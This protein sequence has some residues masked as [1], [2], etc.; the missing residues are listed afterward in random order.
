M[1]DQLYV[2]LRSYAAAAKGSRGGRHVLSLTIRLGLIREIFVLNLLLDGRLVSLLSGLTIGLFFGIVV[3]SLPLTVL[4]LRILALLVFALTLLVAVLVLAILLV[5]VFLAILLV[6][7]FLVLL[8]LICALRVVAPVLQKSTLVRS[9]G[10][11]CKFIDSRIFAVRVLVLI[12]CVPILLQQRH[13]LALI[14]LAVI[15]LV[16]LTLFLVRIFA[17]SAYVLLVLALC[18][19]ILLGAVSDLIGLLAGV[20]VTVLFF[21]RAVIFAFCVLAIRSHLGFLSS[22]IE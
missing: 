15:V 1:L 17:F 4:N 14:V 2:E 6:R 18:I 11:C 12:L 20:G 16:V 21:I 22:I 13:V 5:L 3:L 8:R 10:I 19:H 7:A 9:A